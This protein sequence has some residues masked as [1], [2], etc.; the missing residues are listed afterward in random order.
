MFESLGYCK[1]FNVYFYTASCRDKHKLPLFVIKVQDRQCQNF[2]ICLFVVKCSRLFR[3]LWLRLGANLI[4]YS[5]KYLL[6]QF[7]TLNAAENLHYYR[8]NS[9]N[10]FSVT[11]FDSFDIPGMVILSQAVLPFRNAT[12]GPNYLYVEKSTIAYYVKQWH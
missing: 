12:Y 6:S 2:D 8:E 10:C 9:P 3:V 1:N 7:S 11:L 5:L 4:F